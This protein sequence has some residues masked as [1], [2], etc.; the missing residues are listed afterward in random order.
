MGL[1]LRLRLA[2]ASRPDHHRTTVAGAGPRWVAV[3]SEVPTPG[4]P[5]GSSVAD[6]KMEV[7]TTVTI[8]VTMSLTTPQ[9]EEAATEAEIEAAMP[10]ETGGVPPG[11]RSTA[12]WAVA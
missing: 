3:S 6:L 7:M 10:A 5:A 9:R 12:S 4:I 8:R 11:Q 1:Q 2:T